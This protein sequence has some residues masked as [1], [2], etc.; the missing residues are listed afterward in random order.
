MPGCPGAGPHARSSGWR[1]TAA[2]GRPA[3]SGAPE[4][5]G[6]PVAAVDRQ[7]DDRACG[8]APGQPG[9]VRRRRLVIVASTLLV[10]LF[11]FWFARQQVPVYQAT[12]S[13]RYEQSTSLAGLMV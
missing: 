2:T 8:P 12:A 10:A 13:V 9:I 6:R 7:P 4:H 1:S 5:A 3:C 11:S